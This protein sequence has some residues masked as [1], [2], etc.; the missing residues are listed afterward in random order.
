M[1]RYFALEMGKGHRNKPLNI[2]KHM[3][4]NEKTK[5]TVKIT[6]E[7]PIEKVWKLWTEPIHIVG[8]NSTSD[9]WHSPKAENDLREG[10]KFLSRMEAKDGSMGFD[11]VGMYTKVEPLRQIEYTLEDDRTVRISFLAEGDKTTITETFEAEHENTL[12]LQQFG[13][14][15]IMNNFKK[16]AEAS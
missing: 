15:S 6:V 5:L 8:W 2:M 10:G 1:G 4:T 16:Y 12:E 13:W 3:K 11:F 9:D 14:Q 7:S